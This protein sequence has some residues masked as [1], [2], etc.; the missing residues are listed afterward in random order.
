MTAKLSNNAISRLAVSIGTGDT[1]LSVQAGDGAKFPTITGSDWFPL[2]A[3]KADGTL[4]I[5]KCTGR[6]GDSF[7]VVRAQESTTA[8]AFN[9]NDRIELR[10]TVGTFEDRMSEKMDKTGGSLSGAISV[11]GDISVGAGGKIVME[12]TT[13]DAYEITIDPGN[14]TADRTITLPDKGGTVITSEGGSMTGSLALAGGSTAPTPAAN[15]NTTAI[16]T[17]AMVQA[18]ID[19]FFSSKTRVRVN[20]STGNVTIPTSVATKVPYNNKVADAKN[21]FDATTNYRFK[22]TEPGQYFISAGIQ[23]QLDTTGQSLLYGY[24]NGTRIYDGTSAGFTTNTQGTSAKFS[25]I[26]E[27]DGVNDYFEMYAYQNSSG[28]GSL[29]A[30]SSG[31]YFNATYIG[32]L[33]S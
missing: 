8:K 4:E 3:L 12:G 9:A 33:Q 11:A 25:E 5:M 7:T 15:D 16:A 2:T 14:P 13:D 6:S 1:S 32:P 18:A 29:I 26:V 17:T 24:K 20:R 21:A 19:N 10:L 28:N 22:P 30:T 31:T 23:M 27:F